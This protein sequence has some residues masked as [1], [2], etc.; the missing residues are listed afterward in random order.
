MRFAAS[1]SWPPMS[2]ALSV[3]NAPVTP[4]EV[5]QALAAEARALDA[6]CRGTH[7][8]EGIYPVANRRCNWSVT[9]HK[10]GGG[11]LPLAEMR[12][13]V[14]RVQARMPIVNFETFE[15][16]APFLLNDR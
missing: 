15:T 2:V 10:R 9:Y 7:V 4:P 5:E 8:F 14:E 16:F 3:D 13:A 12:A 6:T 11:A 1:A